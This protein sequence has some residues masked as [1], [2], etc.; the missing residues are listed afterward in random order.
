[1]AMRLK[2]S[3]LF[4][5]MAVSLWGQNTISSEEAIK[6]KEI[7]N[8]KKTE[9]ALYAD[10]YQE[11]T[12]DEAELAEA[13]KRSM[14]MLKTHVIEVFS[15]RLNMTNED[16]RE[17][18][19]TL[20]SRCKN[21]VVKKGDLFRV[22]T[23]VMKNSLGLTAPGSENL[24]DSDPEPLVAQVEPEV[25]AKVEVQQKEQVVVQQ[26]VLNTNVVTETKVE[27]SVVAIQETKVETLETSEIETEVVMPAP[28]TIV[29]PEPAP[30]VEVKVPALCQTMFEKKNMTELLK[31][32]R[33]EKDYQ[34][35]MFGNFNSMQY[36]E[37]CYI[38]ILDRTSRE[39]ITI[40]DKGESDRMNFVSKQLDRFNNYR[41]GNYSAI[42]VQ[43]Y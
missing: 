5:W 4:L 40:L 29:A 9:G 28:A 36:P 19:S 14:D 7:N 13:Q 42:F 21:I 24:E 41:G 12:A 26:E 1:M 16:V 35:L 39:I 23:Y 2:I 43:E 20:E 3:V 11:I 18:W 32:L 6:G 25:E 33:S 22:F 34:H 31:Y 30:V 38:V 17:I 8:I 37:K 10:T 15:K 27:T